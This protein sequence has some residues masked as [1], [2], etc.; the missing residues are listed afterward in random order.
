MIRI[1]NKA[2]VRNDLKVGTDYGNWQFTDGMSKY[3]DKFVTITYELV[4]GDYKIKEDGGQHAWS[5]EM[6]IEVEE[7]LL[8]SEDNAVKPKHYREGKIDL[9]ESWYLR[10]PFNE[11]KTG[12]VM[13]ADRYFNRNKN[14]RVEDM[15]KGLYVMQ[16]LKEY[17]ELEKGE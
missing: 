8:E 9:I 2:K 7:E 16:R 6:L 13:Y 11:F 5:K 1:G 4:D 3:I 14:N 12:M 17:E 15:E 10:Y